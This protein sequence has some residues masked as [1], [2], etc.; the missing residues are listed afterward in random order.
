VEELIPAFA[1]FSE[2]H[3]HSRIRVLET[4][5]SGT[6][7]ALLEQKAELVIGPTTPVG[8]LGRPLREVTMLP[9]AA[10]SHPLI[11][12]GQTVTE[13]DLRGHRQIVLR[14]TGSRREQDAGWLGAQQRWTVSHFSSSLAVIKSGVAFAFVPANWVTE[15]LASGELQ[16]I[17][18]E[19]SLRRR[20]RLYLMFSNRDV[21]GPATRSLAALIEKT[22][23]RA[24]P[25]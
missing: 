9:V 24:D 12:D 2:L 11:A 6:S 16:V 4:S 18:L 14:D 8:I 5:L 3:P 20:I 22:L 17:D 7:E 25:A 1:Q 10:P 19:E 13:L 23:T 15:E 21:A